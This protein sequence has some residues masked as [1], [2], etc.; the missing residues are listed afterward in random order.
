[1]GVGEGEGSHVLGRREGGMSAPGE[2]QSCR[3]V[4]LCCVVLCCGS[5]AF[6]V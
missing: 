5:D 4:M 1:M 3:E 6:A 2:R